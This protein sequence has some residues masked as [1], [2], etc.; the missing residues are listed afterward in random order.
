MLASAT[1]IPANELR[2]GSMDGERAAS[3][4]LARRDLRSLPLVIHDAPGIT[5][6]DIQ[7]GARI[8]VHRRRVRLIVIDDMHR[9][10]P[11]DTMRRM[12]ARERIQ[13]IAETTK[14]MAKQL[15][16]PVLLLA[17]ISRQAERR[18]GADNQ[19]PRVSDLMY[20]GEADAD[21]ILLLW[22]PE[23]YMG[24]KPPTFPE[25]LTAEKRAEA[26]AAWWKRRNSMRGQAEVIKAKGRY[27]P[28]GRSGSRS[29]GRGRGSRCRRIRLRPTLVSGASIEH[30]I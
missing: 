19:R 27:G 24:E 28:T 29:T 10:K 12:D 3:L 5:L 1:G 20:G 26:D 15:N 6:H 2:M 16:V 8:A 17:Q 22:R 4:L 30:K 14:D 23:L 21:N 13:H 7:I 25:R 18:E 11:D 9:I